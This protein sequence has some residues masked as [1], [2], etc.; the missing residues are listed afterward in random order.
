MERIIIV[1]L[2]VIVNMAS[3]MAQKAVDYILEHQDSNPKPVARK[4]KN[5]SEPISISMAF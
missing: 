5:K 3:G 1:A 2:F 4:R